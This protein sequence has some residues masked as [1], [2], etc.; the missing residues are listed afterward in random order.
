M[1]RRERRR[2]VLLTADAPIVAITGA[3]GIIGQVVQRHLS[4]RYRLRPLAHRRPGQSGPGIDLEDI[5][6]LLEAFAGADVVL[7]LAGAAQVES[8][9]D[10][11]LAAN[12]VGVRNVLEA[13]ALT[14][15]GKVV[16]ASSNHVV[17]AYEQETAPAIYRRDA[18]SI[19][20]RTDIRADSLYG[21]SKAFGEILG[22]YYVDYHGLSV[23]C[24]RI[25]TVRADD[26]P[27][28]SDIDRTATWLDLTRVEKYERLS[29]TRLSHRDCAHLL[30]AAIDSPLRWAVVFG[31]SDNPTRIWSLDGARD[32]L[33]FKPTERP[34]RP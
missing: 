33:G 31:V 16:L 34:D 8:T 20:E 23:I 2:L 5:E 28:P 26:D 27:A 22:R 29:S 12:I 17:G 24:I 4:D 19:D 15:I 1:L 18:P 32:L 13:A 3:S 6:S 11:V 21:V 10:A 7:H 9:W 30:A 25:G 14:G